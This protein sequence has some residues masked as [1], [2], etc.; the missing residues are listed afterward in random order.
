[1]R[2]FPEL[3]CAQGIPDAALEIAARC[4][5]RHAELL[6]FAFEVFRGLGLGF[7]RVCV[8]SGQ[9][10]RLEQALQIAELGFQHASVGEFQ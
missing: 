4:V 5:Q 10:A 9:D 8:F 6:T 3:H 1:M 7:S 2:H